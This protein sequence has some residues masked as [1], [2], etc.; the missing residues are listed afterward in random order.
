MTGV[1][2]SLDGVI[3]ALKCDAR[4]QIARTATLSLAGEIQVIHAAMERVSHQPSGALS[5]SDEQLV[6]NAAI[7]C[8]IAMTI[9]TEAHHA[10]LPK[11]DVN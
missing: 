5:R 1:I 2:S 3:A 7:A 4:A 11:T 8:V 6:W 9:Q 10:P